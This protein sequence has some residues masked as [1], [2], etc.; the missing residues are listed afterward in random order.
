M[1]AIL[2][3][4]SCAHADIAASGLRTSRWGEVSGTP[5]NSASGRKERKESADDLLHAINSEFIHTQLLCMNVAAIGG[6]ST[7]KVYRPDHLRETSRY[8]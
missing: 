7:Q 2:T 5:L 8:R 3:V 1:V 6:V 4:W